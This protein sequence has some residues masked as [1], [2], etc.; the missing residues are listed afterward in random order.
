MSAYATR[1]QMNR[2]TGYDLAATVTSYRLAIAAAH[3]RVS[4]AL[5]VL[6]RPDVVF[7]VS[8]DRLLADAEQELRRAIVTEVEDDPIERFGELGRGLAAS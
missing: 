1:R 3:A 8:L 5:L 2:T 4:Q 6:N 7:P